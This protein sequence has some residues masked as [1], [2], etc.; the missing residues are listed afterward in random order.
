MT[1][2]LIEIQSKHANRLVIERIL[3]F[4]YTVYF[5]FTMFLFVIYQLIL[6]INVTEIKYLKEKYLLRAPVSI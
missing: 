6:C 1:I 4:L 5:H 2:C 3:F